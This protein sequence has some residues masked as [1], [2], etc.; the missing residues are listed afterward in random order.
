MT[1]SAKLLFL[2]F[3]L[4]GAHKLGY[5]SELLLG[6]NFNQFFG[7]SILYFIPPILFLSYSFL[8]KNCGHS[9]SIGKKNINPT[10]YLF[11]TYIYGLFILGLV[12]NNNISFMI[13]DTWIY[14]IVLFSI[15]IGFHDFIF[16]QIE[17]PLIILFWF[18]FI[19]T[20]IADQFSQKR[21]SEMGFDYSDYGK[22][23]TGASEG[24]NVSP[25]LDFWPFIFGLG[26]L[27]K[28]N[29]IWKVLCM[30][31]FVA[32]LALQIH[33]VKR[34][35]SARSLIMFVAAFYLLSK[36]NQKVKFRQAFLYSL[37]FITI[38]ITIF[39]F[40]S[41][42]ALKEKFQTKDTSRVDEGIIMLQQIGL[43]DWFVGK[44]MGGTYKINDSEG[45]GVVKL[46]DS[47]TEGKA[48]LHIGILNP[49]LKGGIILLLF[50]LSLTYRW[51]L[52]VKQKAWL[53]NKYN[54]IA[55]FFLPVYFVFQFIEGPF[56]TGAI[57]NAFLFGFAIARLY[58]PVDIVTS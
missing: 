42:G 47:G 9:V 36:I 33:F 8:P 45:A 28:K 10:I 22:Y 50:Y 15:Y 46:D 18:F 6:L 24:Y 48:I 26:I 30:G 58:K 19:F 38:F 51:F 55:A 53:E 39:N 1:K 4:V 17:K 13:L 7:I 14:V 5:L 37:I 21:I 25:I 54:F 57:F 52:K 20:L 43:I 56:S 41:L 49:L 16:L 35:P 31:A 40:S 29:D 32:Y 11:I 3:L 23:V 27:R 12:N 2:F 34:A 44:G